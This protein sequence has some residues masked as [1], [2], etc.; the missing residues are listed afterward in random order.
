MANFPLE[1]FL[2]IAP[3]I[4]FA[5]F[6]DA[7]AGGGGMISI[8]AYLAAGVPPHLVLGTNKLSSAMGT[9]FSV[10]NYLRRVPVTFNFVAPIIAAALIGSALGAKLVLLI[11]PK[12]IK[13]LLLL[14]L[15]VVAYLVYKAKRFGYE[16]LSHLYTMK[17]QRCRALTI[18]FIIG[19][20]DGFFGPGTGTFLAL[21][22]T[23]FLK[24][25]LLR[26][27]AYAKYIN[28]SSNLAALAT[29]LFSSVVAVPLGLALG[30]MSILG[31]TTGSLLALK[32]G[33]S[34]IRPLTLLVLA[35]LLCK[36]A[37]DERFLLLLR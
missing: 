12:W 33:A 25:D 11:E 36:I 21:A 8:P 35:A 22:F 13:V 31:H 6:V 34:I 1:A 2:F 30:V 29:F 20:Y 37:W 24:W 18:A 7:I 27:T 23:R 16:D 32:R 26:A 3:F 5:G 14:A 17:Q 15:P 9:C 10:R 4:F 28:L 19:A